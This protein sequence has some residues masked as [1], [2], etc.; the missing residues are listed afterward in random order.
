MLHCRTL[1]TKSYRCPQPEA[2]VCASLPFPRVDVLSCA[3]GRRHAKERCHASCQGERHGRKFRHLD[4]ALGLLVW[5]TVSLDTALG[6]VTDRRCPNATTRDIHR[7]PLARSAQSDWRG[8]HKWVAETSTVFR[9]EKDRGRAPSAAR[10]SARPPITRIGGPRCPHHNL[11]R[12]VSRR[13]PG[14]DKT[15][16][17]LI[18]VTGRSAVCAK[19]SVNRPWKLSSCV[20]RW[21]ALRPTAL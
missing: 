10:R 18:A 21:G 2:L 11:A 5:C 7:G 6:I 17:P 12:G 20:R 9:P 4:T 13:G 1:H 14:G 19:S 3:H 15:T 8:E 16:T